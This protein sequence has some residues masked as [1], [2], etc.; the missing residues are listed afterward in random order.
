MA[1]NGTAMT[2]A[3]LVT[4]LS[5]KTGMTKKDVKGFLDALSEV[6]YKEVKKSKKK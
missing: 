5:D 3:Q 1:T 6:A 4:A 2:K